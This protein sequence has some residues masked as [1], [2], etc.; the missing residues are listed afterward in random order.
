MAEEFPDVEI[1]TQILIGKPFQCILQWIE[2]IDPSLLILSR[3][4]NH[5]IEGTDMGS[6]VANLCRL[7]PGNILV[8]ST[9]GV[10]PD[11]IPWIWTRVGS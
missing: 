3:H 5:R 1:E 8:T 10:R 9:L 4:G 6:Q 2:E 7:A 11:D